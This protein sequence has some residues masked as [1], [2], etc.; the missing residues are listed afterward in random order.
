MYAFSRFTPIAGALALFATTSLAN[1]FEVAK[2]DEAAF[3]AAQ[4]H[5]GAIVV[6]VTAPWCPTCKAQHA[7]LDTIGSKPEFAKVRL[8]EVDF[9]SQ[10]DGLKALKASQQSTLIAFNGAVET[11][12]V[13]G[14]TQAD[15]LEAVVA[16]T[17]KR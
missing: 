2:Y 15:A 10:K 7:A 13:V 3:K 6:H 9:D 17:M 1:A 5:G 8:F 12:R 4:T 16:G 14:A 11:G